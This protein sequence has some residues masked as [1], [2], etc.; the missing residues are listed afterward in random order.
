MKT[1]TCHQLGGACD[2]TFTAATFDEIGEMSKAHGSEMFQKGD[3]AHLEA[4]QA[5]MALMQ[6]PGAMQ[7]WF[8]K[9]R[10][11]FDALPEN[12]SP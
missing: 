11:A 7:A 8:Q 9:K 2:K 3:A 4:M 5:M 10:D 1:M 6:D 12:D